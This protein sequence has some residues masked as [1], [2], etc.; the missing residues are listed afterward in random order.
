MMDER[1]HGY[2]MNDV[3]EDGWMDLDKKWIFFYN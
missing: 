1:L 3:K 2:E